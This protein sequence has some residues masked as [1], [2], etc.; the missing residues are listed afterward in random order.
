VTGDAPADREK[1]LKEEI[2]LS[3][4]EALVVGHHGS[5]SASCEEYLGAIGGRCAL[6]SVGKNTYGLPNAEILERLERFGYTVSRTD[7]DGTVEIRVHG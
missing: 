1:R 5:K 3:S 7:T 2:D 6:I 4:V